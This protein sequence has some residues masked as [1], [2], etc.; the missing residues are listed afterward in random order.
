MTTIIIPRLYGLPFSSTEF[1]T[2][3]YLLHFKLDFF[4]K[5]FLTNIRLFTTIVNYLDNDI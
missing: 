3:D 1:A 4:K 2:I 5:R